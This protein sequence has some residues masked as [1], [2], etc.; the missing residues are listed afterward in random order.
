MELVNPNVGTIF[1]MLVFFSIV[2]LILKKYAWRPIL[3]TLRNRE[4]TIEDALKSAEHA[5]EEI[6]QQ[7]RIRRIIG[8]IIGVVIS[9]GGISPPAGG[10]VSRVSP[11]PSGIIIGYCGCLD[12][13]DVYAEIRIGRFGNLLESPGVHIPDDLVKDILGIRGTNMTGIAPVDVIHIID[14]TVCFIKAEVGID[15]NLSQ[16]GQVLK[17]TARG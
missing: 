4:K 12:S 11:V 1:W 3:N 10:I 17:Q 5:K 8:W 13:R 2:L 15:V 16:N 6:I 9:V 14:N 7:R